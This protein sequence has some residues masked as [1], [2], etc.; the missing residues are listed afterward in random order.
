MKKHTTIILGIFL[1]IFLITILIIVTKKHHHENFR[2]CICSDSDGQGGRQETCQDLT[3]V[4]NLYVTNQLTE[5][6]KFPD[7]GWSN[8][9]PGDQS[10]PESSGCSD[11]HNS[12]NWIKWD[13]TDFGN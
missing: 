1:G 6:S 4:N 8:V 3:K 13:F 10:F 12:G 11:E 7:K 5:F 9:S 2:K